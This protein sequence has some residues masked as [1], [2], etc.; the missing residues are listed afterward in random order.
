VVCAIALPLSG[1]PLTN[2][3]GELAEA[4]R[5]LNPNSIAH[6]L[7]RAPRP[8]GRPCHSSGR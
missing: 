1:E 3:N 7:E 2:G 8:D 4:E 5:V 6:G